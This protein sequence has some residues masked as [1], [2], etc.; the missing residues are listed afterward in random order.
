MNL[1][2]NSKRFFYKSRSIRISV[3]DSVDIENLNELNEQ[4]EA[5]LVL[6]TLKELKIR[7]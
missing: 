7:N 2:G 4:V 6:L 5:D 3:L 1:E